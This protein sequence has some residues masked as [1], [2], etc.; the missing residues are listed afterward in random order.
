VQKPH[1]LSLWHLQAQK[2]QPVFFAFNT[3]ARYQVEQFV[4]LSAASS[5]NLARGCKL[6]FN[7]FFSS[8]FH[9]KRKKLA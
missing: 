9:L 3:R 4:A 7:L 5:R 1:Q 6:V 2:S 8:L